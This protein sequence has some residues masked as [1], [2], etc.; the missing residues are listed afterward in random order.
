M[1]TCRDATPADGSPLDAMARTIWTETFGHSASPAD[2]AAYLDQAY[3]PQGDLIRSL[4]DPTVAVRLALEGD[5]IVGYAKLM[6]PWVTEAADVIGALQLGQLYV[7]SDHHGQ[8]VARTLMSWTI[9][10]ARAKN[11]PALF[12][13]VWEHNTRAIRFYGRRGFIHVGDYAFHVGGQVDRDLVMK[14]AL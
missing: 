8:G 11:A 6:D 10:T 4:S 5:R 14:L 7:A 12:L 9:D 13:T 2:V 1:I 3:G